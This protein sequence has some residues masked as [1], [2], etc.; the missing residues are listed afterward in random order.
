MSRSDPIRAD[1]YLAVER[2]EFATSMLFY[3]GAATS[4][5]VLF[6]DKNTQPGMFDAL[7]IAFALAALA[8]LVTSLTT[9]LYWVPR[10]EDRRQKDF[11]SSAL[12]VSLLE[13]TTDGYYNPEGS[14]P[15]RRIAAQVLEN[16]HFTKAI[17]LRMAHVERFKTLV[18][19]VLWL[20]IVLNRNIEL[21]VVL[22]VSQVVFSEE[23]VARWLR[24]EWLRVRSER[25]F[26][27]LYRMFQSAPQV[28]RF[29]AMTLDS[30]LYYE[31]SKASASITLSSRLFDEMNPHLSSRWK[32]IKATLKI[33]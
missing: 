21:G 22:A 28:A 33:D 24:L 7:S 12:G 25:T 18:Y 23:I 6:V 16:S 10:A 2:A 5:A 27:E 19:L 13:S 1:Y 32:E 30:L 9:R 15:T 4:L 14:N 3:I 8:M 29:N 11:L 17:A 26:D 20:L 31:R